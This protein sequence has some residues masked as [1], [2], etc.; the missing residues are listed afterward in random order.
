MGLRGGP[1]LLKL[2]S[3][4]SAIPYHALDSGAAPSSTAPSPHSSRPHPRAQQTHSR[5]SSVM[6]M[7]MGRRFMPPTQLLLHMKL[8]R[9]VV[10]SVP[11]CTREQGGGPRPG[12]QHAGPRPH[13]RGL[14][15]WVLA[16]E[17][18][19]G[20]GPCPVVLGPP[21]THLPASTSCPPPTHPSIRP[22]SV[23]PPVQ[24]THLH[25]LVHRRP[26][27]RLSKLS[28]PTI[29][30]PTH[31]PSRP[32]MHPPARPSVRPSVQCTERHVPR[33]LPA[34]S[35]VVWLLQHLP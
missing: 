13:R 15:G 9:M 23:H 30:P 34:Q 33:R 31:P 14:L 28:T 6:M 27:V 32:S 3:R 17:A 11:T 12:C 1:P 18:R 35:P 19:D 24:P 2:T 20:G 5:V 26:S 29:R 8:Y 4:A 7:R 22:L 21:P 25:A 10:N 16:G